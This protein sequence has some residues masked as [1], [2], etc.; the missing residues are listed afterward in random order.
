MGMKKPQQSCVDVEEFTW[1]KSVASEGYHV[2]HAGLNRLAAGVGL[3]ESTMG[4]ELGHCWRRI[5]WEYGE[6]MREGIEAAGDVPGQCLA[7][8]TSHFIIGLFTMRKTLFK[9]RTAGK[10]H[11]GKC[12]ILFVSHGD[13]HGLVGLAIRPWVKTL[14]TILKD[15]PGR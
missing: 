9:C 11:W 3:A 4:Y 1:T 8:R 12:E 15:R 2:A 14:Y 13:A 10:S 7:A 5:C 6:K